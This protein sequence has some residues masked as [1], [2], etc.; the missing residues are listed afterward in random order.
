MLTVTTSFDDQIEV[1]AD[2]VG[3]KDG[4]PAYL[5]F[6]GPGQ[7]KPTHDDAVTAHRGGGD[8]LLPA[9]QDRP[10]FKGWIGPMHG[11]ETKFGVPIVRYETQAAYDILSR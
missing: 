2:V 4:R 8:H 9:L 11:G 10:L 7:A 6:V 3:A 1:L 5:F